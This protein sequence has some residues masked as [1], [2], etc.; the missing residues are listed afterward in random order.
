MVG[1]NTTVVPCF[2]GKVENKHLNVNSY[3]LVRLTTV[4][5]AEKNDIEDKH[6]WECRWSLETVIMKSMR[7]CKF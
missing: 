7:S 5:I 6:M 4:R 1:V 2:K 3:L